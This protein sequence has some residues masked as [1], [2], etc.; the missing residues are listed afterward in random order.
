MNGDRQ[1][2]IDQLLAKLFKEYKGGVNIRDKMNLMLCIKLNEWL[3]G[4]KTIPNLT[5]WMRI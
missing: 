4:N 3:A 1:K 2:N 5:N